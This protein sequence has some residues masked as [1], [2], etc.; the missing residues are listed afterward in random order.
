MRMFHETIFLPLQDCKN[1]AG[2]EIFPD[3]KVNASYPSDIATCFV[4]SVYNSC[5]RL[6][7]AVRYIKY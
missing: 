2:K 4:Y 7:Y 3:I 5:D 6:S 1:F